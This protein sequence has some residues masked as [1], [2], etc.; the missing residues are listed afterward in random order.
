MIE[1]LE[2]PESLLLLYLGVCLIYLATLTLLALIMRGRRV[3]PAARNRRFAVVVPAHNEEA[4]IASTLDSLKNVDYP[5]DEREIILIADNCTDRTAAI[6]RAS[7][8]TVLERND[9]EHRGKGFAL[10]WCFDRLVAEDPL[11]DAVVIVDADTEAGKNLLHVMNAYLELG[12]CVIQCNDMVKPLP[13]AWSSEMTR[14]GF[15]LYNLIRPLGRTAFGG[16]AGLKGNGMCFTLPTLKNHPWRAYSRAEDLEYG[17]QLLVEGIPVTFAP[18]ATILATM[19]GEAS[20]AE[21]QR[22]RWEGGRLP[23]IRK[24]WRPLLGRVFRKGSLVSLDALIELLCPALVNMLAIS[25]LLAGVDSVL[26][27]AGVEHAGYFLA[28]WVVLVCFGLTHLFL[29]I[30]VSEDPGLLRLVIHLP[31]FIFWKMILYVKLLLRGKRNS[32]WVR[33]TR[34]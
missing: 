3:P 12:A 1:L 2:I 28:G 10:R 26:A 13:G 34:E 16:S 17:L 11:R 25:V 8:V 21:S 27:L 29:G 32:E 5:P 24:Y 9:T 33:T 31:R 7:G 15:T 30:Y 19:P 6:A 14:L 4:G 22:A 23:L 20:H 18:E